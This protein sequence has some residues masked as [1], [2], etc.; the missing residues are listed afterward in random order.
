[1]GRVWLRLELRA[2]ATSGPALGLLLD[3]YAA[4]W[5]GRAA[6]AS[7]DSMLASALE[8]AQDLRQKCRNAPPFYGYAAVAAAERA[9]EEQHKL[10][11]PNC[12]ANSSFIP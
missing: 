1:V 5:R 2:L 12:P 9:R 4:A 11:W 8:P 6:S 10:F 7:L 3:R